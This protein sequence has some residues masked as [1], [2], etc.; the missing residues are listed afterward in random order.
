MAMVA[1]IVYKIVCPHIRIYPTLF[2]ISKS[3]A[4]NGVKSIVLIITKAV[5]IALIENNV[6]SFKDFIK[7]RC[8]LFRVIIMQMENNIGTISGTNSQIM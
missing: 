2:F 7:S 6:E 5:V 8:S 3:K 4:S 1:F